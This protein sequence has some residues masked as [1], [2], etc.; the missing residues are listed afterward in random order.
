MNLC[1][2]VYTENASIMCI[3][4][5]VI[6]YFCCGCVSVCASTFQLN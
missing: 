1:V 2:R 6:M 4:A 3:C 5:D